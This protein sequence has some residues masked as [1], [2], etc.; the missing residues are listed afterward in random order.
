ML[1][2]YDLQQFKFIQPK[3]QAVVII[4]RAIADIHSL[5]MFD[6]DYGSMIDCCEKLKTD[7]NDQCTGSLSPITKILN[8]FNVNLRESFKI[9]KKPSVHELIEKYKISHMEIYNRSMKI[10]QSEYPHVTKELTSHIELYLKLPDIENNKSNNSTA[11]QKDTPRSSAPNTTYNIIGNG[12]VIGDNSTIDNS[13]HIQSTQTIEK[14]TNKNHEIK[15]T[16]EWDKI[17]MWFV[18]GVIILSAIGY[19]YNVYIEV[20]GTTIQLE[21]NKPTSYSDLS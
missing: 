8:D 14:S 4:F 20:K 9:S 15:E 16:R 12:N 19:G 11:I 17:V 5:S 1:L 7:D 13:T 6:I 21:N 10:V 18:I 2:A 3:N